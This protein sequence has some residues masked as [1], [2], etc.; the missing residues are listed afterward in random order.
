MVSK[1]GNI[2]YQKTN[3]QQI[4]DHCVT[5]FSKLRHSALNWPSISTTLAATATTTVL[6]GFHFVTIVL[7]FQKTFGVGL[8]KPIPYYHP[9]NSVKALK[10][11]CTHINY[12]FVGR[13]EAVTATRENH[14]LVWTRSFLDKWIAEGRKD[15]VPCSP[16]TTIQS[17][18][19]LFDQSAGKTINVF[20][21]FVS[22]LNQ[23][24]TTKPSQILVYH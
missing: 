13:T 6:F 22:A 19:L 17:T 21:M 14:P 20:N 23:L 12:W 10:E 5:P 9:T 18:Q 4:N 1:Y 8:N 24:A 11:T 16:T 7:V 3:W 2:H 15:A